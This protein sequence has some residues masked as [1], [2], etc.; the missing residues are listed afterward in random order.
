MDGSIGRTR[1]PYYRG[2]GSGDRATRELL[3][4]LSGAPD[5]ADPIITARA[6]SL[7]GAWR[8][9]GREACWPADRGVDDEAFELTEMAANT[10]G[11]QRGRLFV[12]V[13]AQP[14]SPASGKDKAA[15]ALGRKGGRGQIG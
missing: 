1:R 15:Q 12:R 3:Q 13:A 7:R 4:L 11:N 6:P 8:G 5:P 14:A 2:L 10:A 9:A